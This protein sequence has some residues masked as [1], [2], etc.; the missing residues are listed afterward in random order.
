VSGH[1][2]V[3]HAAGVTAFRDVELDFVD[4][5]VDVL[6]PISLALDRLQGQKSASMSYL[7]ASNWVAMYLINKGK[8]KRRFAATLMNDRSSRSHVIFAS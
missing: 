3:C 1:K 4:E 6:R 5:Y 7:G 8:T 2:A